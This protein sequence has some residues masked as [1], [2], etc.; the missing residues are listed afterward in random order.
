MPN[1]SFFIG[2]HV[3]SVISWNFDVGYWENSSSL[4]GNISCPRRRKWSKRAKMVL[5]LLITRLVSQ[6]L[7]VSS[8]LLNPRSF[9]SFPEVC[10][11]TLWPHH[12]SFFHRLSSVGFSHIISRL[13]FLIGDVHEVLPAYCTWLSI[14]H[15]VLHLD[16]LLLWL[17]LDRVVHTLSR[18][19]SSVT[20]RITYKF[21]SQSEISLQ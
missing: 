19:N 12:L 3:F 20:D 1:F 2:I 10:I 6:W 13:W 15:S 11:C 5:D 18:I 7:Q 4:L 9:E 17:V 8:I 16:N 21:I 14:G